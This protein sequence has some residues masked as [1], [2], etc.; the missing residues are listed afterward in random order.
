VYHTRIRKFWKGEVNLVTQW[1]SYLFMKYTKEVFRLYRNK[2]A[3]EG[4]FARHHGLLGESNS[5][6][7]E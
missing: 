6:M 1:A 5:L 2:D 7:N 4:D 3:S